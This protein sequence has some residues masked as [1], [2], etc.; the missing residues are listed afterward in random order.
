MSQSNTGARTTDEAAY[1][2][3]YRRQRG[4]G[5]YQY[6]SPH[7]NQPT[8]FPMD[9]WIRPQSSGAPLSSRYQPVDVESDMRGIGRPVTRAPL[10]AVTLAADTRVATGSAVGHGGHHTAR[11]NPVKVDGTGLGDDVRGL[12]GSIRKAIAHTKG[13]EDVP[14]LRTTHG[15]LTHPAMAMKGMGL[16]RFDPVL[17]HN[18]AEQAFS[19]FDRVV[20]T[21]LASKDQWR[22]P[23]CSL[24]RLRVMTHQA[25]SETPL[26][27]VFTE[28]LVP[29][30]TAECAKKRASAA[31]RYAAKRV[32]T[33]PPAKPYNLPK[34]IASLPTDTRGC[35]G[36]STQAA[37]S[38]VYQAGIVKQD[39]MP[40]CH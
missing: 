24:N 39:P 8:A 35:Y 17:F 37:M 19:P 31:S 11:E 9:S 16:N 12:A 25:G 1:A 26:Q 28:R 27:P 14:H 21:R 40:P 4:P 10:G 20:S 29:G 2:E 36:G 32:E 5:A 23:A 6:K 3:K 33:E 34:S 18:P 15:R 13:H 7:P 38:Q 30:D 22:L